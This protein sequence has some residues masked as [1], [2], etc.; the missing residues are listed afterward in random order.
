MAG[1]CLAGDIIGD[2]SFDARLK[3]GDRLVF[4][5]MLHY[6]MVKNNTFNGVPL[7]AIGIWNADDTFTLLRSFDY[8][9]YKNRL[10]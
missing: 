3:I 10:S 9:D 7:P 6:S 8:E 5:D 1:A 2:Y 4:G